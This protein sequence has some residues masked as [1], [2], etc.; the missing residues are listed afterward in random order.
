MRKTINAMNV[1]V[2]L[3]IMAIHSR[4]H[5]YLLEF[6]IKNNNDI[7]AHA[8]SL[9]EVAMAR[10]YG[11]RGNYRFTGSVILNITWKYYVTNTVKESTITAANRLSGNTNCDGQLR[12]SKN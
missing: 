1:T 8:Q 3:R 10:I 9:V 5:H 7:T 11:C 4:P 12:R 6:Q 2:I